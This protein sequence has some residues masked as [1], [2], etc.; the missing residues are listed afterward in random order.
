M[1]QFVIVGLVLGSIYALAASGLVITYVSTG[2]LNFAFGSLAYFIART[3]YWIHIEKGWGI[4]PSAGLC[5]FVISPLLGLLLYIGIF[6]FL[7]LSSQL[8]KVVVTIGLFVAI[9]QISNIIFGQVEIFFTPG[10]APEP[11]H[12]YPF[13]GTVVTLNQVITYA[14]LLA[15]VVLGAIVL[16]FTEAGLSVR[17]MVDSE[18]MT[19]LSGSDP[20]RIAAGVWVVALFLAGLSGILAAPVIGLDAGKFTLLTAAAFAA[21]IAA[22]LRSL[23][24]A[25]FVALLMGVASSLVQYYL[26]TDSQFTA[27]VIPSIPF[28]FIVISLVY[29]LAR[30]GRVNEEEG[31]GGALDRAITPHGGSRLA[32]SVDVDEPFAKL[33]FFFPIFVFAVVC[34]VGLILKPFWLG[35]LG[36]AAALAIVFLSFTLVTG[37]GGMLWLC[38]IAF[39]GIGAI[40]AAWFADNWGI[41]ILLAIVMGGVVAS[42]IGVIIGLLTIRLGNLYIALVTLTFALLMERLVFTLDTFAQNGVGRVIVRPEFASERPGLALSQPRGVRVLRHPHRQP[43]TFDDRARVERG[44]LE[45]DRL[46]HDGPERAA[47]EA[48]RLGPGRVR[49]RCRRRFLRDPAEGGGAVDLRD[50]PRP[51]LAGGARHVR[52][53]LEHRRAPRRDRLHHHAGPAAQLHHAH[54]GAT[55]GAPLRCRRDHARQEPRGHGPHAGDAGPTRPAKTRGRASRACGHGTVAVAT[56]HGLTHPD[57]DAEHRRPRIRR[58]DQEAE[59]SKP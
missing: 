14:C 29:N 26:P 11:V 53:A 1:L 54:V 24:I 41:P 56:I 55:A 32:A 23:P 20:S 2:V 13:F 17:A 51:G 12:T 38:Q 9:P 35:Q 52:R 59:V 44:A 6:R 16:R 48:A 28:V 34:V 4:L 22:R 10:L 15:I 30:L 46:A 19:S 42:V 25:V 37:E 39:A 3:Y 27:A 57:G 18:A 40:G 8:I 49:R 33:N 5:L 36:A 21:V 43:Q 7:R 47:D 45:R 50:P 58:T 31:V